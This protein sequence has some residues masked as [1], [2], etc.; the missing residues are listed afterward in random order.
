MMR[1][2]QRLLWRMVQTGAKGLGQYGTVFLVGFF[3]DPATFGQYGVFFALLSLFRLVG[4][5][6][7]SKSIVREIAG[8]SETGSLS[9]AVSVT[10]TVQVGALLLLLIVYGALSGPV[11]LPMLD[12]E[13]LTIVLGLYLLT[14][15]AQ[16][17]WESVLWGLEEFRTLGLW[18]LSLHSV[19]FG[20]K[21]AFAYRQL[22]IDA[23]LGVDIVT[24]GLFAAWFVWSFARHGRLRSPTLVRLI[25]PGHFR[26]EAKRYLRYSALIGLSGV[27]FFLYTRID[28]LV[29]RAYHGLASVGTLSLAV[30]IFEVP[31][32]LGTIVS[33]VFLPRFSALCSSDNN[34][35]VVRTF[36]QGAGMIGAIMV[37][38]AC[39]LFFGTAA[40]VEGYFP[41]YAESVPLV[42]TLAPL[43]LV[44][45][46]GQFCSGAFLVGIG[47]ADIMLKAN[48]VGGIANV[49]GDFLVVERFGPTGVVWVTVIVHAGVLVYT[50]ARASS[51][52]LAVRAQTLQLGEER[53]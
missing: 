12:S 4:D 45:G 51:I 31:L 37:A 47:R 44:K 19:G 5:F 9:R 28:I 43:L 40:V 52:V 17:Y 46:F 42:R 18:S 22:D 33:S 13:R 41:L 16:V 25:R 11:V 15:L 1:L 29:L 26:G 39:M 32:F 7:F 49:I 20:T 53:T 21:A 36:V 24:Q 2:R 50:I 30:Q 48:L 23:I 3:Y 10:S 14:M 38:S 8:A 35:S 27:L 34:V 6:G